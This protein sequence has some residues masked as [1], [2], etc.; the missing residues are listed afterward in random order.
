VTIPTNQAIAPQRPV[1]YAA[2]ATAAETAFHLPTNSVEL[3]PPA[4]N[5]EGMRLTRVYAMARANPGAV[6]HCQLYKAVGTTYTYIDGANLPNTAPSA[7]AKGGKIAFEYDDDILYGP[8][9]LHPGEGL[10]VAIGVAVANGI[11]FRAEGGAYDA[12]A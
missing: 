7:N 2:I 3:I 11:V 10:R 1:A 8:L 12:D 4:D 6:V 5:T 9:F